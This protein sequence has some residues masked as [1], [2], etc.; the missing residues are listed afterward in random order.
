MTSF[1]TKITLEQ[2]QNFTKGTIAEHLGI[3][4]LEVLPDK[5]VA[6]MPVDH[7]TKQPFGLLH[8]GASVVLAEEMGSVASWLTLNPADNKAAVGLEINAN[9]VR[10][11]RSGWVYGTVTPIHIG[12]TTHIWQ[13]RLTDEADNLVCI[14]RLTTMIIDRK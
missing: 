6:R 4:Y 1:N 3:E 14:S 8:G 7:R 12:K 13:I 10:G 11:L 2:I 5:I 9:H